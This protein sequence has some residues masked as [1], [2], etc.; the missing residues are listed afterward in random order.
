MRELGSKGDKKE[1]GREDVISPVPPHLP[2]SLPTSSIF[3]SFPPI[4]AQM[5]LRYHDDINNNNNNN[6]DNNN[7]NNNNNT[8]SNNNNN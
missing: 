4:P 5:S 8:D 2:S 3:V 7:N 6:N 1:K